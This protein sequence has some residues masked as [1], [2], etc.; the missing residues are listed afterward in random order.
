MGRACVD[1]ARG[2]TRSPDPISRA[3]PGSGD[4][5]AT[6]TTL[7]TTT[8]GFFQGLHIID[9]PPAPTH[10]SH[11]E[12]TRTTKTPG[13]RTPRSTY[14]KA[15]SSSQTSSSYPPS[16]ASQP[17]AS[18]FPSLPEHIPP[19]AWFNI[20][21]RPHPDGTPS[22]RVDPASD[23]SLHSSLAPQPSPQPVSS[24]TMSTA[25]LHFD[26]G[27]NH[28]SM[29]SRSSFAWPGMCRPDTTWPPP[30]VHQGH[31]SNLAADVVL[32]PTNG[33][34]LP[35]DMGHY[36]PESS[37]SPPLHSR[38]ATSSPPRM[39]AEQR[40]LKRQREQARRDSKLSA[41]IQRAGSQ[42]SH[43]GYE[44]ASPP[45]TQG[46]FAHTSSMSSMPVYTTAPTDISL[47]TEPT[48]L[49]PQMVLPSYSPPLPSSNQMGFPSPYQQ[50]QYID[51]PYP[52]STGAPLSSHYG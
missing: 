49:A 22:L 3:R 4:S 26:P 41:R 24:D 11:L 40:E 18:P 13:P 50:P 29:G 48:T 28:F 46:D 42:G 9:T 23:Y 35:Q 5:T 27:F 31:P 8:H 30:P 2:D 6:T 44:V 45:S 51:Y 15:L 1:Q 19:Q 21:S 39:S 17:Q 12:P 16:P 32:E 7:L 38:S 34:L 43:S 52:P 14:I 36:A 37:L 10:P 20:P 33:G 47:L 25:A